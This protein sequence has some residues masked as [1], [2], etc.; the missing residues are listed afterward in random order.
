MFV[1][2]TADAAEIYAMPRL[3]HS[4]SSSQGKCLRAYSSGL[5]SWILN[6]RLSNQIGALA[7]PQNQRK[8]TKLNQTGLKNVQTKPGLRGR[9]YGCT[10]WL[11]VNMFDASDRSQSRVT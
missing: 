9:I 11:R 7:K 4:L 1:V 8:E 5:L 2:S 3:R 10:S 6:L